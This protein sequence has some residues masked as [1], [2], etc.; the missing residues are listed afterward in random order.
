MYLNNLLK[1]RS[2]NIF[3]KI[4]KNEVTKHIKTKIGK[5]QVIHSPDRKF[6]WIKNAKVAGTSMYRGILDKE[7]DDLLTYKKNPN[8]FDKWWNS[9][10]DKKLNSYFKFMF[11]RNPFDRVLS[12]FSHIILEEV[13]SI[14]GS[15]WPMIHH[16]W[17]PEETL[18]KTKSNFLAKDVLNFDTVLL[19][20][21]L[22]LK[23]GLSYDINEDSR[24]WMPQSILA[25]CNGKLI[26]DFV[27]RYENLVM[28]W[29]SVANK[30]KV[31]QKLPFV[32]I[33][34]TS[35]SKNGGTREQLQKL[36]WSQYYLCN[37]LVEFVSKQYKRDF[38]LFNYGDSI[39]Q[40]KQRIELANG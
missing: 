9:L 16:Y 19:L 3:K 15:S 32:P 21:G 13:L 5:W 1:V 25:E 10:T 40:L 34:T 31:S 8:K 7:V 12:A 33:S 20:F 22:F 37:E 28:D 38:E 35:Q 18:K 39:I 26:V 23:R 4:K 30:L 24:H 6:L 11:V 36:Q 2:F 27:G 17:G 14:Y 29:R